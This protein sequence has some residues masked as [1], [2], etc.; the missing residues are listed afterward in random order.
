MDRVPPWLVSMFV[1]LLGSAFLGA[2][3]SPALVALVG[4]VVVGLLAHRAR[5]DP[6]WT[7]AGRGRWRAAWRAGG[8]R[9]GDLAAWWRRRARGGAGAFGRAD[10]APPAGGWPGGPG[11]AWSV[12][13]SDAP[14]E[15]EPRGQVTVRCEVVTARFQVWHSTDTGRAYE[16]S[17]ERGL[18]DAVPG[19]L[20]TLTFEG[21]R[22]RVVRRAVN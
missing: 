5:R 17:V 7:A 21:G 9:L 19:D 4:G 12:P 8:S 18:V 1:G 14:S 11:S 16:V 22:P 15:P 20:G 3:G 10:R 6:P 2:V 13:R